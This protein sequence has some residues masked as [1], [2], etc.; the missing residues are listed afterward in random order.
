MFLLF[1][2]FTL[3]VFIFPYMLGHNQQSTSPSVITTTSTQ[4]K[5]T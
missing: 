1:L 5:I 2:L 3:F 4:E